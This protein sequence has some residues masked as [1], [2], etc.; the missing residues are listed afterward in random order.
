[1]SDRINI[2]YSIKLKDLPNETK[3]LYEAILK[4]LSKSCPTSVPADFLSIKTLNELKDLN[5]CL[6]EMLARLADLESIIE[7]H[8]SYV[9]S[10]SS[11]TEDDDEGGPTTEQFDRIR[12]K[13]SAIEGLEA[14][15]DEVPT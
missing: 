11:E 5:T 12:E 2:T 8:L 1:M 4:D 15:S 14:L 13:L 9:L 3:R 7:G 10:S 6:S